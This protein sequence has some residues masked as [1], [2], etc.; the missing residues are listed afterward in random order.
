N[1]RG[2]RVEIFEVN[3]IVVE[4]DTHLTLKMR[5][6]VA[7]A[8]I[9]YLAGIETVIVS[10]TAARAGND[11]DENPVGAGP[12]LLEEFVP[13]QIMRFKKNPNYFDAENIRLGGIEFGRTADPVAVTNGLRSG[14]LD[15]ANL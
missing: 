13:D 11:F 3:E 14:Q 2:M 1:A 12:F 8:V 10:P 15:Y 9:T 4:D 6:P 7:G 5:R